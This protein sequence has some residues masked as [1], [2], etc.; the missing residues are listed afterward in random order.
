MSNVAH[1]NSQ[2]EVLD[3]KTREQSTAA[4]T[5][6]SNDAVAAYVVDSMAGLL[7]TYVLLLNSHR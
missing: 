6:C 2:N 1:D 3:V 4:S 5:T 7:T